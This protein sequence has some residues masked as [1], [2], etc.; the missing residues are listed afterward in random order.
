MGK[1]EKTEVE[2]KKQRTKEQRSAVDVLLYMLF[3]F[4]VFH[5]EIF[6]LNAEALSNTVV[7]CRCRVV[8]P[9]KTE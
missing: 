3:T 7:G 4:A 9:S 8:D 2:R 5:L 1:G 6:A